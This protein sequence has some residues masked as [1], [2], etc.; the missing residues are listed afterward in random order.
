MNTL[1]GRITSIA[2]AASLISG[3]AN[4]FGVSGQGT[5][6]TTLQGRDLDGN[7]ATFEAYYD[8][9]LNITWLANANALGR[10]WYYGARDRTNNLSFTDGVNVYDNWRLP[11]S[12]P[13]DGTNT[14]NYKW[15]YDGSTDSG[16]NIS[17]QGTVYAGGTGSELAHLFYNTLNNK[18]YCTPATSTA[19]VCDSP[20]AGFGL[21]NTGPFT[22]LQAGTY[23]SYRADATFR[24]FLFDFKYGFQAEAYQGENYF[25][26][27]V[28]PGDVGTVPEIDT[29]AML[30]IGLG[31]VGAVTRR[32]C[33]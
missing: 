2:L 24:A 6:E 4:A 3:G 25:T 29:W 15:A 13:M 23:W 5:W 10:E 28:S 30:L 14:Y 26:L 21:T 11:T 17:E 20:Q 18:G 27:A 32:R 31:L 8:T 33:G 9:N 19:D 12:A 7:H 1:T 16:Y 22:N